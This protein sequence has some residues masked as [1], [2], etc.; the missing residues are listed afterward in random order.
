[1]RIDDLNERLKRSILVADG[2][3][4]S[5][6]HESVDGLRCVE[7]LNSSHAED[8]FRAHQSYIAAGAQLIETNT[9][10][11]NRYKLNALGIVDRVAELNH[12][13]VKLAREAREAAKHDVLIG[14]SIGPLGVAL[15]VRELPPEEVFSIFKEQAGALEERGVDLFLLETFSDVGEL[16][17]AIDAIRSFSK[18]PIVAELTFSEEGST[19][20]GTRPGEAWE[21]LKTKDIQAIGANCTVGPQL[22]IPV[23]RELAG[24][25]S[26]PLSAMP[27]AG[28]PK[29]VGDRI[30]YPRSSPEYFALFARDAAALGVRV[31]G[32]CCG[33][34]PEHVQAIVEA[35]KKLRPGKTASAVAVDG[36]TV[37]VVEPAERV[38]R[39]ARREPDSKLWQ[40]IQAGQFVTSVEIDPPKGVTVSRI[41]EQISHVMARAEIDAIDINSG[42]LARVGMDALMLAAALEANGF[43]T[44]PHL[45]TRDANIIG[46]QAMLLGAWAV[47][48]VRNV[49]AI[50]G[51]PPSVGDYPETNGVYELD[52]IGLVKVLARLNQGTDWA[53]KNLGGATNFTIGVAVNPVADDVDEELRRFEQKIEAGAHFAM[54]QP[55]FEPEQWCKFLKK[56]GGRSPVPVL[57]GLWPLT[58]YRLALRLHNEV[59]GIVVPQGILRDMEQ[60]GDKARDRGFEFARVMLDWARTARADGIAGAYLIP[61]FKRYEGILDLFD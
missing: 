29:R 7:E 34:T 17:L 12:R 20:G 14:G 59:A 3:M 36:E 25:S 53:G 6:L 41:V 38:R 21:I 11:A 26:L 44:I 31:M 47:G 19:I 4:G 27:N 8:V 5:L 1:M 32:G 10:G 55:I 35:V 2:A 39:L 16:S 54:T 43:E 15:Q 60:A 49:L 9:F 61:P 33:T 48:G 52:S 18:L 50:T 58:S 40:K 46:L 57:V 28:F 22:L 51:D 56:L 23:L 45:T 13:G 37:E 24:V 30:V 42:S